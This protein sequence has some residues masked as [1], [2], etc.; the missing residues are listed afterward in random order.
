MKP[1]TPQELH[2]ILLAAFGPQHWWPADTPFEVA[3]GAVLTQNTAWSNVE[4]AIRALAAVQAL[5]PAGILALPPSV[6]EQTVRP[7]G[8]FRVK[9]GYLR[10][11][12]AWVQQRAPGGLATLADEEASD[13]RRELLALRGIGPETADSILLYALGKPLVVADAYTRRIGA[14]LGMLPEGTGYTATQEYLARRLPADAAV[15]GEFHAL[16]VRLGKEFCGKRQRCCGC[17]LAFRCPSVRLPAARGQSVP[18]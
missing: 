9:A 4:Q 16:V 3:V 7:A 11:L 1:M 18:A 12:A 2:D 13:L 6:L 8:Y 14:R 15:L 10:T 17:P 5:T